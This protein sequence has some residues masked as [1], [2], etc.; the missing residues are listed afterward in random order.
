MDDRFIN[1][2]QPDAVPLPS[3]LLQVLNDALFLCNRQR[4]KSREIDDLPLLQLAIPIE[5]G[6]SGGP[7][8]QDGKVVG[9]AFQGYSGDVAQNVGY[10]IPTPVVERFLRMSR[11]AT[12][13]GMS[14]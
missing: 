1:I 11:T 12:M 14:I 4:Q 2:I 8:L 5:Q 10:M 3:E 9:V 7:V 6:N 13:I